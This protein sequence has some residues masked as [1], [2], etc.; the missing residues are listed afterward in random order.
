MA[1]LPEY[2]KVANP[3]GCGCLAKKTRRSHNLTLVLD[4]DETLIHSTTAEEHAQYDFDITVQDE[5]D[6]S[7]EVGVFLIKV[8]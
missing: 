3:W 1:A 5:S 8:L 7:S 2:A 4:M 6:H